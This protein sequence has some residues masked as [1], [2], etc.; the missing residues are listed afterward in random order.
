MAGSWIH[1][2]GQTWGHPLV[3]IAYSGRWNSPAALP[4]S[5]LTFPIRLTGTNSVTAVYTM[6]TKVTGDTPPAL[7]GDAVLP[8]RWLNRIHWFYELN[9]PN[10][11]P[12]S[13][14]AVRPTEL[15]MVCQAPAVFPHGATS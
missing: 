15:H 12:S 6:G 8:H 9:V 5:A 13:L 11:Q 3:Q 2:P 10:G 4:I 14:K 1:F 7:L